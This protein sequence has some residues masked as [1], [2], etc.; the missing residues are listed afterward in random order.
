MVSAAICI[1]ISQP[2][3]ASTT[4]STAV[5]S[6]SI[7][8]KSANIKSAVKK[9]VAGK[10]TNSSQA[11]ISHDYIFVHRSK[12]AEFI[13]K[14]K[15]RIKSIFGEDASRSESYGRIVNEQ[16]AQ[17]LAEIIEEVRLRHPEKIILGGNST[18]D[19]CFR[20]P[21][22]ILNP[23]KDLRIMQEEI[24]GPILPIFEYDDLDEV[25]DFIN[26]GEKPLA[27]YVFSRSSNVMKKVRDTTS[28][29]S[30]NINETAIHYY[31]SELPFGGNNNSGIG[32]AHGFHGFKSFSHEKGIL[33][34]HLAFSPI[35][36]IFPPYTKMSKFWADIFLK[37]F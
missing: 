9:I 26:A 27:L 34:Q 4:S 8:D 24:F 19:D 15:E 33:R 13:E 11:C 28:S 12:S 2:C 31:H 37:Y 21:T 1:I 36:L 29:G 3:A 5:I 7:I 25:I 30:L 17:R 16:N 35:E 14:F 20:S 32:K 22:L 6:P 23:D 10:Y 18:I